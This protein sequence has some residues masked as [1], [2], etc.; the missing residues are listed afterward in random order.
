MNSIRS[1]AKIS[2]SIYCYFAW[3]EKI[4]KPIIYIKR[5]PAAVLHIW[6]DNTLWNTFNS[7]FDQTYCSSMHYWVTYFNSTLSLQALKHACTLFWFIT[8][9]R[10]LLTN[11][12]PGWDP[13]LAQGLHKFLAKINGH[14]WKNAACSLRGAGHWATKCGSWECMC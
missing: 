1:K 5:V 10:F 14:R 6:M 13:P 4:I 12:L 9:L 3:W 2:H 7:Q 11:P 8:F